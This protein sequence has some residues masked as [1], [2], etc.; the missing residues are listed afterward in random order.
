MAGTEESMTDSIIWNHCRVLD[1]TD[2]KG[3][4]CAKLLGGMGAEVIRLEKPQ[5]FPG[6]N[7]EYADTGKH[8]LTLNLEDSRGQELFKTIAGTSDVIVESHPPG[9][10]TSLGLGYPELSRT[11]PRLIMAS[12]T[13]FGQTGP[14]R[15]FV[16]SDL[17]SSAMGGQMSVCG[18][19]DKPPLKPFGPQAYS[20]ASL[21]AANGIM[22][23]L[24]HRRA[25]GRG[26]YLDI[27]IHESGAATLD[28]VMVRYFYE[29]TVA[30]RTGRFN[31]NKA[32]RIFPCRDG[33]ILLS[34]SYQWETLVGWLV[35]EG[36]AE[37]L[38]DPRWLNEAERQENLSHIIEVLEKW[39]RNHAADELVG[40]GQLMR[41]P[42]ARVD[43][44]PDV[45]NN[46]QLNERGFF[47]E[48]TDQNS[49]KSYKFPGAPVKMRQ[50]PWIVRAE[51]P[52]IADYNG[53]IYRHELG[54]TEAEINDLKR[55]G[56]I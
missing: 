17:V 15:D 28:H 1:L 33:H 30:S 53:K 46:P 5:V 51:T 9:Y 20:I 14:Y 52:K 54:L 35:S 19:P 26:Q 38:S 2:E 12:I 36:M 55:R 23:A 31:W 50:S 24:W 40:L 49:A 56:V 39:T 27:S 43:S 8:R 29:G 42:W 32:F 11:H 41:F 6:H 10:L 48:V 22:L 37:D 13:P 21:F 44:I 34:L 25:S 47:I 3:A 4:L 7:A 18:D 16:S 45:V